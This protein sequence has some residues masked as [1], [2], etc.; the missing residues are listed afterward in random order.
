MKRLVALLVLVAALALPLAAAYGGS[1]N[2]PAA[3]LPATEKPAGSH[4]DCPYATLDA[5]V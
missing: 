3:P 5:S 4:G 1:S 2:A